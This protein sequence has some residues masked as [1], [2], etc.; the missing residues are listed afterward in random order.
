MNINKLLNNK[1]VGQINTYAAVQLLTELMQRAKRL[2]TCGYFFWHDAGETIF[3]GAGTCPLEAYMSVRRREV[4]LVEIPQTIFTMRT[5]PI[6]AALGTLGIPYHIYIVH[7]KKPMLWRKAP[8]V[9]TN[10]IVFTFQPPHGKTQCIIY[11]A[12]I[13]KYPPDIIELA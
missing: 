13:N 7:R 3:H 5:I 10:D 1:V 6:A 12:T 2:E 4:D 9:L 11:T 8:V